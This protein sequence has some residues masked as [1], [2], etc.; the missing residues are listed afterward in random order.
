[1]LLVEQC[2]EWLVG[3]RYLSQE[4]LAASAA[5]LTGSDPMNRQAKTRSP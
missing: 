4:S 5:T 1:M 3:R 2:V